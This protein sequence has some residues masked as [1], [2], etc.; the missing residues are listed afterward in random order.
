M[1]SKYIIIS[2]FA[3]IVFSG[4]GSERTISQYPLT[5]PQIEEETENLRNALT[6]THE[7]GL[8]T[9][10]V[11]FQ[12][13]ATQTVAVTV[14]VQTTAKTTAVPV[15]E[16]TAKATGH[17]V[18]NNNSSN[19]TNGNNNN[20]AVQQPATQ[21]PQPTEPQTQAVEVQPVRHD[22]R[23]YSSVQ[24]M[25]AN[26]TLEEK[27]SQMFMVTPE[28]L[29]GEI[30]SA[31][32]S[33]KNSLLSH[34][35]GGVVFFDDN[36]QSVSQVQ[37][38]VSALND[39]SRESIGAGLFTAV[40]EESGSCSY[41]SG[42]LGT[43]SFYDMSAYGAEGNSETA[44]SIGST[45]GG[46]L[47]NCGFNVNFAPVADSSLNS[48][49]S[50]AGRMFS[51]NPSITASMTGGFTEGIQSAGV[52]ATLKY[53]PSLSWGKVNNYEWEFEVIDRTLD[54]L[55]TEEFLPFKS[56]INAGADFVMVGHQVVTGF[57]DSLPSDLS[58]NVITNTLKGELGFS[59]VVI[60]DA[61]NTGAMKSTYGVNSAV[62]AVKAGADMILMPDNLND[63]I[64]A[65]CSAVNSGEIPV[66]R[67]DESVSRILAKKQKLGLV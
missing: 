44:K 59:G 36:L 4:C 10:A 8:K 49:N 52:S 28:Q 54:Q 11:V 20:V 34:A 65:V 57:G 47:R 25:T 53:F 2:L 9:T 38:F 37:G 64:N 3:G 13:T 33:T 23:N 58:Y 15:A 51:S 22:L 17:T 1:K 43:V 67:I 26:M 61:H 35:V 12:T 19:N 55:R 30:T 24:E 32:E 41:V 50:M 16:T 39:Y 45:I 46:E 63:A 6:G 60:T 48:E 5:P 18:N 14:P 62:M 29:G 7:V 42:K 40:R 66:S 21:T 56:G 31:G 27:V